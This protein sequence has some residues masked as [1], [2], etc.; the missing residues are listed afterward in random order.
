M[1]PLLAAAHNHCRAGRGCGMFRGRV[2]SAAELHNS[3]QNFKQAEN[4]CFLYDFVHSRGAAEFHMSVRNVSGDAP[5]LCAEISDS[6]RNPAEFHVRL[7]NLIREGGHGAP[8]LESS[9]VAWRR[10]CQ[11]LRVASEGVPEAQT[12]RASATRLVPPA[13]AKTTCEPR[14]LVSLLV[15]RPLS[16]KI[17][18]CRDCRRAGLTR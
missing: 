6:S 7:Q 17:W 11:S 8:T 3:K 4:H 12:G 16:R 13:C 15:S 1:L 10:V 2:A 5:H 9:N 14:C 18:F